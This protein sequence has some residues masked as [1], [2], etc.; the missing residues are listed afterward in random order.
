MV[1]YVKGK[2]VGEGEADCK[3][4]L[5]VWRMWILSRSLFLCFISVDMFLFMTADADKIP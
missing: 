2:G 5:K 3:E 1:D 4:V